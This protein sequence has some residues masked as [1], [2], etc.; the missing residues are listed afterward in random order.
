MTS[1]LALRVT[2]VAIPGTGSAAPPV[3]GAGDGPAMASGSGDAGWFR[4]LV[5][6]PGV[7]LDAA[8]GLATAPS[9]ASRPYVP[10]VAAHR[11]HDVQVAQRLLA[12]YGEARLASLFPEHAELLGIEPAPQRRPAPREERKLCVTVTVVEQRPPLAL[13]AA[14]PD[15]LPVPV[16]SERARVTAV[17]VR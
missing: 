13:T 9:W 6:L 3:A 15:A 2:T 1:S 10:D 7:F 5:S 4:I 8:R 17:M 16:L 14:R 12:R 11:A